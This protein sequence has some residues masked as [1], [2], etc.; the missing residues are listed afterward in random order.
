MKNKTWNFYSHYIESG[1]KKSET[2]H[3]EELI[4]LSKSLKYI[5]N[6]VI[7]LFKV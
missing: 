7:I 1:F 3:R 2:I 5:K 4:D 6:N